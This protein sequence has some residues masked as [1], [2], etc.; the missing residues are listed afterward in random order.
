MHVDFRV[1]IYLL[2]P[3]S[4][5]VL[6]CDPL[7]CST[8]PCKRR[9]VQFDSQW[10]LC[11]HSS[12]MQSRKMVGFVLK[13]RGCPSVCKSSK[14]YPPHVV[15][16]FVCVWFPG[17]CTWTKYL[18]MCC[19][20]QALRTCEQARASAQLDLELVR[21][22]RDQAIKEHQVFLANPR[23]RNDCAPTVVLHCLLCV[24]VPFLFCSRLWSPVLWRS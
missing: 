15:C 11:V 19:P 12:R 14:R 13:L 22:D 20:S 18:C 3:L 7:L 5:D 24:A 1:V 2:R 4:S 23:R 21:V 9:A 6:G 17:L 16:S 8:P 10:H